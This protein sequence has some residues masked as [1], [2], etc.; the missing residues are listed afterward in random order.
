MGQFNWAWVA[1]RGVHRLLNIEHNFLDT[2]VM[3]KRV[4]GIHLLDQESVDRCSLGC[5]T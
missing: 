3:S 1:I 4:H 5:S 2:S